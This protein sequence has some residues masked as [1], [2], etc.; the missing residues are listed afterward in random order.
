MCKRGRERKREQ[1]RQSK[2]EKTQAR[3]RE[4]APGI[5]RSSVDEEG[6][7]GQGGRAP[8]QEHLQYSTCSSFQTS[9]SLEFNFVQYTIRL[10]SLFRYLLLASIYR[11]THSTCVKNTEKLA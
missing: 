11:Q 8:A 9:S 7:D 3:E 2:E 6:G 4:I 10:F 5:D 1:E